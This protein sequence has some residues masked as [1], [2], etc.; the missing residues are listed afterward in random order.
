VLISAFPLP[1]HFL[2]K[3]P[4]LRHLLGQS[5]FFL[6]FSPSFNEFFFFPGPLSPLDHKLCPFL[7]PLFPVS[8]K[9]CFCF[10]FSTPFLQAGELVF[11]PHLAASFLYYFFPS[12]RQYSWPFFFPLNPLSLSRYIFHSP[13]LRLVFLFTFFPLKEVQSGVSPRSLLLLWYSVSCFSPVLRRRASYQT[14]FVCGFLNHPNCF[15]SSPL[16]AR[17]LGWSTFFFYRTLLIPLTRRAFCFYHLPLFFS[18][19]ASSPERPL[20]S[21]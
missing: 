6:S 15:C 12:K 19:S 7:L 8:R 20:F 4:P 11:F 10:F 1:P 2:L 21:S 18:R 14:P 13:L 3:T 16:S 5:F 9:T 17:S